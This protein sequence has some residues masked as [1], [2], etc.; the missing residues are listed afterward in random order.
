M[1]QLSGKYVNVVLSVECGRG[2]DF[3]R[4][5]VFITANF[6]GR[7][8]ESD[9]IPPDESPAFNTELVWEVEKK[10]LRKIRCGNVPLRVECITVDPL[11]RK[12]RIG[13]ALLSLRSAKIVPQVL[14][15]QPVV[16]TWHKLIGCQADKRKCHPELYISL[17][18]RDHMVNEQVNI[19]CQ[20][21]GM[22]FILE[23]DIQSVEEQLVTKECL[24]KYFENGHIQI[25]DD[26]VANISYTLNLTL[27]EVFNLDSLLTESI[28]FH[29][30]SSSSFF[31]T[32]K[33]L[34]IIIKTK[35]F[36]N[37]MCDH[38]LL[39][40]KIVVNLLSAKEILE[41]FLKTQ[42]V[43]ISFYHGYDKLGITRLNFDKIWNKEAIKYFFKIPDGV[44]P[45]EGTDKSPY[46]SI[47]A[48]IEENNDVKEV[49]H[50]LQDNGEELIEKTKT[51]SIFSN[52]CKTS[53]RDIDYKNIHNTEEPEKPQEP[54]VLSIT[55]SVDTVIVSETSTDR[56]LAVFDSYEKFII[57][58]NLKYLIWTSSPPDNKIMFKFLH[59]RAGNCTTIFTEKNTKASVI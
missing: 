14:A 59:P 46:I 45:F 16:S 27:V 2:M 9:T 56:S 5:N 54:V 12:E 55:K 18:V 32:F 37:Q 39:N 31:L 35:P 36:E 57:I 47:E 19:D 49:D 48:W 50:A 13:F 42:A 33:I 29:N 26:D 44:V 8:L 58:I 51:R 41:D 15:D 10:E 53:A 21:A 22:P 7:I 43:S 4:N 6:N 52:V 11:N 38:V 23:E 1:N 34:G 17:S 25:G 28:V 20:S 24:I 40:E 30:N 3:L